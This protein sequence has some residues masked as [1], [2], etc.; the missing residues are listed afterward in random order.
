MK[1][2]RARSAAFTWNVGGHAP[3]LLAAGN[4]QRE[5]ERTS[6]KNRKA[7]STDAGRAVGPVH[8]SDEAPVMGCGAKGLDRPG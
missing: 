2:T 5:G 4:G 6:G 3:I 7:Q 1:A 8:S